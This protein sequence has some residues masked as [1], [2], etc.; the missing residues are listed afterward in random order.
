MSYE[1]KKGS[2]S[3][4]YWE[5]IRKIEKSITDFNPEIESYFVHRACLYLS[6]RDKPLSRGMVIKE[7]KRFKAEY[8]RREK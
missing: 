7:A 3:T 2:V 5:K 6:L 8:E 1:Y 4:A